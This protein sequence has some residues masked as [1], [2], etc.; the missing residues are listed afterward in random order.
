MKESTK[1]PVVLSISF[2]L[3]FLQTAGA[4]YSK[5]LALFAY[6]GLIIT[7]VFSLLPKFV[8]LNDTDKGFSKAQI[9]SVILNASV[10]F[11]LAL[12]IISK[13]FT[14]MTSTKTINMP[15]AG[16]ITF[17]VFVGLVVCSFIEKQ[18]ILT[19]LLSFVIITGFS[20]PIFKSIFLLDYYLSIFFAVLIIIQAIILIK[21]SACALKKN[22]T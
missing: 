9:V 11:I 13:A 21:F 20:I 6:A 3:I 7:R 15:L 14:E 19:A 8:N 1:L 12:I 17:I 22:F 5:S 4:F 18:F 10:I 2:L 16:I